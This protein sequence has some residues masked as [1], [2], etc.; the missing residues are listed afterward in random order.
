MKIDIADAIKNEGEV[1]SEVYDGQLQ[2]IEFMGEVFRFPDVHVEADYSFD[3]EGVP[4]EGSFRAATQVSC[5]RCLK[6]LRYAVEFGFSEYFA[7]DPEQ[8][9]GIYPYTADVIELDTML[10]DNIVM[11]L[12]MRFLCREDC[13]GLCPVC[14]RDLN[15][16]ECGCVPENGDNPFK[17]AFGDKS[18]NE[19]E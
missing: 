14:G 19:E 7:K 17:K 4:V 12:P 9:E 6:P 8:D 2:D 10:E 11:S 5:S 1:Y 15:E 13:K 18:D 16:G 3:G